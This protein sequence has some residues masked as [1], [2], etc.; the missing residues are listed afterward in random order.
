MGNMTAVCRVLHGIH[1]SGHENLPP[2]KNAVCPH[3]EADGASLLKFSGFLMTVT[4]ANEEASPLFM[5][6]P[7]VTGGYMV[8][9]ILLSLWNFHG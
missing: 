3:K 5:L 7:T 1:G 6:F 2:Y 4:F 8:L 9:Y